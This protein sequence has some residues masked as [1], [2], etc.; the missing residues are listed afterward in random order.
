MSDHGLSAQRFIAHTLIQR[1]RRA[2]S[3]KDM[4]T[5]TVKRLCPRNRLC[6]LHQLTPIASAS[7]VGIKTHGANVVA[8]GRRWKFHEGSHQMKPVR[9]CKRVSRILRTG[10]KRIAMQPPYSFTFRFKNLAIAVR[11]CGI[12]PRKQVLDPT[13]FLRN[14]AKSSTLSNVKSCIDKPSNHFL[15]IRSCP[16]LGPATSRPNLSNE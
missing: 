6:L 4:Q 13:V 15:I 14:A 3:L 2:V 1:Y 10:N 11:G 7:L 5:H 8:T 12:Q 16:N 9:P